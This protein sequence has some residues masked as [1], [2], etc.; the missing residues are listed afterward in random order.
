MAKGERRQKRF[1]ESI[2]LIDTKK[3]NGDKLRPDGQAQAC[4]DLLYLNDEDREQFFGGNYYKEIKEK[5]SQ[6]DK[7]NSKV[8]KE[9]SDYI[10]ALRNYLE[11]NSVDTNRYYKIIRIMGTLKDDMIWTKLFEN[12]P[13]LFKDVQLSRSPSNSNHFEIDFNNEDDYKI[14]LKILP[15]LDY[16]DNLKEIGYIFNR[17]VKNCKFTDNQSQLLELLRA[18][19][20]NPEDYLFYSCPR[21]R[22]SISEIRK[23][24]YYFESDMADELGWEYDRVRKVFD[25]LCKKL[26][27]KYKKINLN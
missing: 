9:Y 4:R 14:L 23:A 18:G 27:N 26:C 20:D 22:E 21:K 25:G 17:I 24:L 13:V 10:N 15:F 8:I 1:E 16:S 11:E 2:S 19:K 5:I 6:K 3:S 7:R 12:E